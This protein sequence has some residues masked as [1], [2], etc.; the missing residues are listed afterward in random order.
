MSPLLL[1]GVS[2][3]GSMLSVTLDGNLSNVGD[4]IEGT[5]ISLENAV[6]NLNNLSEVNYE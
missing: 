2:G 3:L 4:G 5:S 1:D 6:A